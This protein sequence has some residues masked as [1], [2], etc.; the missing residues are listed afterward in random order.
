MQFVMQKLFKKVSA[1]K[2]VASRNESAEIFVVCEGFIAPDRIDEKLL[3]PK[4]VFEE[5]ELDLKP[6][7]LKSFDPKKKPKKNRDGYDTTSQV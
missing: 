4:Y 1:T 2:P 6:V 7:T 5:I 3:D